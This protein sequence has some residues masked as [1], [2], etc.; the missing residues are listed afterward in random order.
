M[1]IPRRL[2]DSSTSPFYFLYTRFFILLLLAS[3]LL[4]SETSMTTQAATLSVPAGGDLQSAINEARGG[5]VIELQA[6]A[7]FV[8]P[9]TLPV[10]SGESYITV[11]SSHLAALPAEGERVT[12]ADAQWMPKILSAGRGEP[13]LRT[14]PSAHHFR[15][16]GIEFAPTDA[17]AMMYHVIGLGSV[18]AEQ[19]TL[20]EVPHHL[21]FD[22]CYIH[23]H[24]TQQL[25]RGVM[26]N[27]AETSI[28]NCY[29]SDFKAKGFD[30]QAIAGWN[31]P[32]P[33]KIINN[34]LEG[35]GENIIFGG[36]DPSIANLVPSDIEIRRNHLSKPLSWRGVWTVKNLF[37]L[38]NARRVQVT[39]NVMEHNWGDAQTGEA[40]LLTVRN[41]DG[42]APWSVVE[43]VE[44]TNNIVRHVG[45]G[46]N[47]LGH[48]YYHAS[49]QTKR[50]VVRNNFFDDIDGVRWQ[51]RGEFLLITEG[52]GE[53]IIDHNTVRQTG[54]VIMAGG[55]EHQPFEF[56]NNIIA[57]NEYGIKGDG[58]AS[59]NQ[60]LATYF[61][62]A[63]VLRNLIV[64]ANAAKY[65][66]DNFY[67]ADFSAARFVDATNGI[68]QLRADSKYRGR[69]TDGKDLGC[70]F[71]ALAA[72]L[73]PALG[74]GLL[75]KLKSAAF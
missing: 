14:A 63:K 72:A 49:Q 58:T 17:S 31:G 66:A 6:G 51:G 50:I 54:S 30:S 37:E 74:Q 7:S 25:I 36:S 38:K 65:P 29:I 46:I 69:G 21:Q 45:A 64:G 39:G 22:R 75:R 61:P 11:Q 52:A 35:A 56:T 41:Q 68:Y 5:D 70:D 2:A 18:G 33:Y 44:L 8:G 62:Q 47:V 13:A 71:E 26:L 12:P 43:D 4:L 15:F 24:P 55:G 10:K 34:Y 48:D 19:D 27:S 67:P 73:P 59:G 20:S 57:H 16:I 53:L 23:A 9:F 28:T 60:S 1:F 3:F 40:I 32:G 42:G